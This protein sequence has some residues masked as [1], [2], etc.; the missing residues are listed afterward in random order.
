M[1]DDKPKPKI[2]AEDIARLF[3]KRDMAYL[4]ERHYTEPEPIRCKW[5]GSVDIMKYGSRKGVQEYICQKCGRKFIAKDAPYKKQTPTEQIGTALTM[6]Y[7]GLSFEDIARQ[8][9]VNASTVYRWVIFYTDKAVKALGSLAPKVSGVWVVDE[10]VIKIVDGNAWFWD[11]IDEGTRFLLASHL[12]SSRTTAD[13]RVLMQKAYRRAGSIPKLIISDKLAAYLDGIEQVFGAS[14]KHI[15]S[16]GLTE[17]INTNLIERFHGTIKERTKVL[18]SFKSI[19]TADLILNGF[20]IH[21]NFFRPHMS[22]A[23]KT[24]AEVAGITSPF[25][26]WTDFVKADK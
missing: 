19:V 10:T 11:V 12:S 17:A 24:P 16:E 6:Y 14:S 5:C 1:T 2:T 21:Y 7:D 26:T 4:E 23:N 9:S 22:L 18:R 8:L 3:K 25:K 20:L 15:Q 13:V